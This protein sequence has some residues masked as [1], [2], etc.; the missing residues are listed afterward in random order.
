M[1][2]V[3]RMAGLVEIDVTAA[4]T[5]ADASG[6]DLRGIDASG[7]A[8]V[9][10][11]EYVAEGLPP[12]TVAAGDA[13]FDGD[14]M[15]LSGVRGQAGRS[16]FEASGALTDVFALLTETGTLSGDFVLR[17]RVFDANEWL[18]EPEAAPSTAAADDLTAAGDLGSARPFDR[19]DVSFDAAVGQLYYDVYELQNASANGRVT[20][21]ALELRSVAFETAGSDVGL[22]G[23]LGNLYGYTFDGGELIG[24]LAVVSRR[25]DLLALANVGVDPNA[26]APSE[27]EAAAAAA[28]AEYIELP[29]RMSITV[30]ADVDRLLYDDIELR[31]VRGDIV[32][33]KQTAAV[34]GATAQLLG[35]R[36]DIDGDYEYLGPDT[37]PKFDLKY[38]LQD[39][40]FKEAF[41]QFNTVR[42]LA[43]VAQYMS[44]RFSTDMVMSSTLGRDMLP[45]LLNLDAD[46]FLRTLDASLQSFGPLQKASNLL[47]VNELSELRLDNTK[48]YFSIDDGTVTVQP[49]E[50]KLGSVNAT[51]A[52]THGLDDAMD[53]DIDAVIPRALLAN[54]AVG[55]AANKGLDLLSGQASKLGLSIA[56]GEN[57]RVRI[58]LTGSMTDPKVGIKLLGTE[59]GDGSVQDAATLALREAAERAK[60]SLR[61]VAESKLDAAREQAE[62]KARAVAEDARAKAQAEAQRLA[63]EAKAKAG[64]EARR[65]ADEAAARAGNEAKRRAEA[66]AKE[67]GGDAVDKGKE[68]LRGILGRKKPDE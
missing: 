55:A 12:V 32:M 9:R 56:P 38:A 39:I 16:D 53:Y 14:R 66:L 68:A 36:L 34:R 44:G 19:F 24:D 59:A 42:Q 40:G 49:F 33:A 17:S 3:Q 5:A 13:S 22:S 48:N 60:D 45:N 58:N 62:A 15:T 29:E 7:M 41:E 4:G 50:A 37:E 31:D 26:A 6:G 21:E 67:Q 61:R 8:R 57:V 46:G 47:G 52:G 10:D 54:N 18:A 2:G 11:V 63:D 28:N 20:S 1:E 23:T 35:G 65:L 25:L 51:I 64:E 43:P 30:D 27:E